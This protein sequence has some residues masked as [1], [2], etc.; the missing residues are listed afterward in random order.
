MP[1]SADYFRY[2][3]LGTMPVPFNFDEVMQRVDG[4]FSEAP[5]YEEIKDTFLELL[6][7]AGGPTLLKQRFD[8]RIHGNQ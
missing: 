6:G 4:I 3:V 1:W 7:Q 5:S 2:R 8:L